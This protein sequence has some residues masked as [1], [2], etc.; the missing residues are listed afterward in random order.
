MNNKARP[1]HRA[2]GPAP[3]TPGNLRPLRS[4][5]P[6]EYRVTYTWNRGGRL[7]EL[8]IRHLAR[9]F[10][11]LWIGRTFGR[12]LLSAA[13]RHYTQGLLRSC[14][15][16]WKEEWWIA[17]KEWRLE[18][19]ADCHYRYICYKMCFY[20]WRKFV[21]TQRK[22][23][24]KYEV[25]E[26]HAQKQIMQSAWHHWITYVRICKTK[27]R[28]HSKALDFRLYGIL[29]NTWH[30]WVVQFQRRQKIHEMETLSLK[31]WAVSLQ[32][33]AWLQWRELY[34]QTEE[35]KYKEQ[36]GLIQFRRFKLKTSL[37]SWLLYMFYRRQK[38]QQNAL[39]LR[40]FH[41]KLIQR[42]FSVW[43]SIFE[44]VK[45]IQAIQEHCDL[46]ARRCVIRRVFTH[47]K[48]YLQISS[49][50]L[51]LQKLAQDHYK[52]HLMDV[53]FHALKK[54]VSLVHTTQLRKML[55]SHQYQSWLQ[56]RFWTLWQYRLEQKEEN[57]LVSLTMAAYSHCRLLLLQKYFS[58]WVQYIQLC[59]FKKVLIITAECHYAK[60]Q[61]PRFFHTW[62]K[63]TYLHQRNREME[64]QAIEFHRSCVQKRV[65]S[66]WYEK[67]NHQREIRL[68]ERMAVLHY[69]WQLLEQYWS[70]WK[71]RL[72]AVKAEHKLDVFASEHCWR[73]QLMHVLNT[74]KEHVQEIKAE[75]SKE[76]AAVIHHRLHCMK[77]FW[78]HWRLFV[79]YR[80]NK[81]Q[82]QLCAQKHYQRC[83]LAKVLNGWKLYQ[84]N[85]K[86]ILQTVV[87]KEKLNNE[88]ILREALHTW[89]NHMMA[90]IEE[91][92]QMLLAVNHYRTSTLR[93]VVRAWRDAACVQAHSREQTAEQVREAIACLQ[94]GKL[95]RL[96]LY[97]R[98]NSKTTGDLRVRME[99]ASKHHARCLLRHCL[100]RWK[101][102]HA[103]HWRKMLLQRQQNNFFRLRLI[104]SCMIKWQ[105]MLVE[106]RHQDKHTIQ[107]L[108]HWSLNLQG[109]VFDCWL[110]YVHE[111]RR[112][113]QR[114]A[115]A[116]DVYRTD[117][118]RE[119]VTRILRL[120]SGM[121][122]FRTELSTQHQ[123]KEVYTQN[124]AVRHCAMIWKKKVFRNRL[125]I[126]GQ[127][128][129][130]TFQ[131][132]FH[133]AQS[134][135]DVCSSDSKMF[136][137]YSTG[138]VSA[139]LL[140]SGEPILS[141]MTVKSE[142][143]K[144]RTPDFL[145]H[146]LEKE[147]FPGDMFID[148]KNQDSNT[149][150][151]PSAKENVSDSAIQ[152]EQKSTTYALEP[153]ETKCVIVPH[154]D[155]QTPAWV[156]TSPVS[157]TSQTCS[158]KPAPMA[159]LMP[160]SSFMP[161]IQTQGMSIS[162]L[163]EKPE[164]EKPP[165]IKDISEY[166]S[167]LLSPTDFLSNKSVKP[168]NTKAV[169]EIPVPEECSSLLQKAEE[170]QIAALQQE[171]ARIYY[172]MQRYQEQKEELKIWR[173]HARVLSKWLQSGDS[174]VDPTEQTIAEEVKNELQQLERQIE[175]RVQILK[176][177]K[178]KVHNYIA[179]IQEITASLDV[180]SLPM[181]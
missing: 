56:R 137:P 52:L 100:K 58:A 154:I 49:E 140:S 164:T 127:K 4:A 132:P 26:H 22:T 20:A 91:K 158:L 165:H 156:S 166:C 174:G 151:Y 109:K 173:R 136:L 121:K 61:L 133:D 77:S 47:W 63:C 171:L 14:F 169:S 46:L 25:A 111:R 101:V 10:L 86:G 60:C 71:R 75:R 89:R 53:G 177:E 84:I 50:E 160:P 114:L 57:R 65:L 152:L 142:R 144:P 108:W 24:Q 131:M 21:Q 135:E 176:V 181:L 13:R 6:I 45:K 143:L 128:K 90:Q 134:E 48:H 74:W 119:G 1:Q 15:T 124:R 92:R 113:K 54:N 97:W 85:A 99:M 33:R 157:A 96:F 170:T 66:T 126:S 79:S 110:T 168:H 149:R 11:Y 122:Q 18:I 5:R 72:A 30:M 159:E 12:V 27:H 87:I 105:Q 118:M 40:F 23:K 39:A 161:R 16:Q 178:T 17:C 36:K 106:K 107:A 83:L 180:F 175:E 34:L 29:H 64:D 125:Q 150:T 81:Q 138:R 129:K 41:E 130:V 7:K 76:E 73:R 78:H 8:R 179:R 37:K 93:Q 139:A 162:K 94:R 148:A 9:K 115:E 141:T 104:K 80:Q 95:N 103:V 167:Q 35:E 59:K 172:N 31:H 42:Y 19:R 68:A 44:E 82:R 3:R 147:G 70:L 51:H 2:P 163:T 38:R 55:A 120:M 88:T 153:L 67:L 116:V 43:V 155:V 32:T 98:E 117:L 62:R 28:M 112:K 69:N 102:Y 146:S 145:L 123:L